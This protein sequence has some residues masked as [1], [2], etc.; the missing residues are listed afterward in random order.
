VIQ[1]AN[2]D[3]QKF[4]EKNGQNRFVLTIIYGVRLYNYVF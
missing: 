3:S 1:Q 4:S 2:Q